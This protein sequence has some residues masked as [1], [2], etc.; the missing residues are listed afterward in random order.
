MNVREVSEPPADA[1]LTFEVTI[2]AAFLRWLAYGVRM[3]LDRG[4]WRRLPRGSTVVRTT[5]GSHVID[6]QQRAG[7]YRVERTH[8]TVE[9]AKDRSVTIEVDVATGVVQVVERPA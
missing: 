9:V 1:V 6:V 4:R 8:L 2:P 7:R 5:A 3:R